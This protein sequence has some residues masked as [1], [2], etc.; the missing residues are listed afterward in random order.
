MTSHYADIFRH[1]LRPL[2]PTPT[3]ATPVLRQLDDIRAVLFDIYGTLVISASGDV[4]TAQ[5]MSYEAA[6][7]EALA[8]LG[9]EPAAA[10]R[11]AVADLYAAIEADHRRTRQSAVDY[12]EVDIVE[13][14]DAVLRQWADTGLLSADVVASIDR[15][16]LAVE[17][18]ART[19]PCWPMPHARPCLEDVRQRGLLLGIISN[20]QF[21]TLPLLEAILERP[22]EGLGFDPDVQFYS[23]RYGR[24]KPGTWLYEQAAE[25][26]R[27][28]GIAAWQTLYVGNDMLNDIWPA[29]RVG[30]RTALFAGD[31]RSLRCRENDPRIEGIRPDLVLT[32]LAELPDCLPHT[33]MGA[34]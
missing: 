6:L 5:K 25:R 32:S 7:A 10:E 2:E 28:R 20:A 24:G 21:Y 1:H 22:P 29:A 33:P 13:I 27:Q 17:Y 15:R 30:F 34:I 23:Y 3:E 9:V 31:G 18:E 14:W 16:R 12:P 4:G 11:A 26:L 8:S 19:N